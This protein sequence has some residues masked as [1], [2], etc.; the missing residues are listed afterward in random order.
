[1]S[2]GKSRQGQWHFHQW[3]DAVPTNVDFLAVGE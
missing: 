1:V 3:L 2:P